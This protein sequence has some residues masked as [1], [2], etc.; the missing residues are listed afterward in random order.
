MTKPIKD[1][2]KPQR[3]PSWWSKYWFYTVL[4]VLAVVGVPIAFFVPPL[5]PGL[6]N[7]GNSIVSV[8]QGILAVLAG[9]LTMLTLSETH[10]KNT[11]EKNK[12]ERDHIRQ[13]HAERRSRYT[14]AVEQLANEKAA[15]RLGGI[16]TLVGLVDEWLADDSLAEDKQQEEGQVIINNLCSYI[17][18]P[19]PLAEEIEEYEARKELEKLQ[20]SESEKLS[21]EESSRLQILLK[22]FE[23]SDEYEKPK[24][25]TTDYAKFH[26]EQDVRRTIFVEMSKRS[27]TIT[28]KKGEVIETVPGIWSDFD[29][30]FS[31][32]PVFYPLNAI[33]IEKGNFS[34]AKFYSIA[35]FRQAS[36][37]QTAVFR[38][39]TFTNTADFAY[40]VFA[41]TADFGAV[42]FTDYSNFG[43]VA[44]TGCL[45]FKAATFTKNVNFGG[46]TFTRTADF[47][48]ATFTSSAKFNRALFKEKSPTFMGGI[49]YTRPLSSARFARLPK[50]PI[51]HYFTV[52]IGSFPI[53]LGEAELDGVKR[54]IPVGTVLFDPISGETSDPAKP[55]NKSNDS[56][57]EKSAE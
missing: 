48:S 46:A 12:N 28:K 6:I 31:R 39:A 26:E 17:R 35:N 11:Q 47:R 22:R 44:F 45:T 10:R 23:D 37:T 19:F 16:Y 54:H 7:D 55:L 30:D 3:E 9:A 38:L 24:D 13:V 14:K 41:S 43:A 36:F 42:A 27:S 32:A 34:S 29:F 20:K 33:T 15:V 1:S 57:E 51:A 52:S 8:R 25:I 5:I 18:S 4:I 56:E 40:A 53:L 21:E 50:N 2:Q 49:G